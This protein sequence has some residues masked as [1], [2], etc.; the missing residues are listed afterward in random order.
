MSASPLARL[1]LAHDMLRAAARDLENTVQD[2]FPVGKRVE[3]VC[4]LYRQTGIVDSH[5]Y[6]AKL[7]VFNT[8]T[9][10]L[11]KI[12]SLDII[13]ALREDEARDIAQELERE[14]NTQ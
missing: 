13:E 11:V 9:G 1:V 8:R 12:S 5:A 3:W 14:G 6:G 4:G 10:T 7:I 2:L